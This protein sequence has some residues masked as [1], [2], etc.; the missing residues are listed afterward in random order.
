MTGHSRVPPQDV[1]T[2]KAVLGAIMLS[3]SAMYEVSDLL[4]IDSFYSPKHR[5]IYDAIL[6][7]QNLSQLMLLPLLGDSK[8]ESNLLT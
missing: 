6:S 5:I 3:Q 7:L 4:H 1:E 2:E 8:N